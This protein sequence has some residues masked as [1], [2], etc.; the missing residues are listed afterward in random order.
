LIANVWY[1]LLGWRNSGLLDGNLD[2]LP[3]FTAYHYASEQLG[4][5][6]YDREVNLAEGLQAYWF[7]RGNTIIWVLWA[8]SI[9]VEVTLPIGVT[10]LS[11]TLGNP[12]STTRQLLVDTSPIYAFWEID[13]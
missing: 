12:L 2:P 11:D 13:S 6:R 10:S 8:K 1:N 9:P 4:S 5:A 7:T 3:A